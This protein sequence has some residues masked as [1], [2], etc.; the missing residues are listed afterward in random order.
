MKIQRIGILA[1]PVLLLLLAMGTLITTDTKAG[2]DD[3]FRD[4]VGRSK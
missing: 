1:A 3:G 4:K 2:W